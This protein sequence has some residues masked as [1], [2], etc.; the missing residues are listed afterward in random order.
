V[1]SCAHP[2]RCHYS[3]GVLVI[4]WRLES[5]PARTAR[6]SSAGLE[7]L[8]KNF[9]AIFI[10]VAHLQPRITI[11]NR[12][13]ME[14][15]TPAS[16]KRT[17]RRTREKIAAATPRTDSNSAAVASGFQKRCGNKTT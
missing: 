3:S 12:V 8:G 1:A 2:E 13:Y 4:F 7:K 15:S 6:E 5:W 11:H 14:Q 17:A 16:G 9:R 10:D